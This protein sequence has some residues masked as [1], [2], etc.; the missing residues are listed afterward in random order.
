MDFSPSLVLRHILT[1]IVLRHFASDD[2][3]GSIS[4]PDKVTLPSHQQTYQSSIH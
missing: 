3:T 1:A 2:S 4:A